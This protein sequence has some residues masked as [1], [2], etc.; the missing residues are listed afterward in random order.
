MHTSRSFLAAA[1]I[2]TV[3]PILPAKNKQSL[4][5]APLPAKVLTAKTIFIQNETN[6]PEIADKAYTQLK[7][8]GRYQVVDSKEK[9]DLVLLF[10]LG[11]SH[12]QHQDS[13]YVSLYNSQTGAYTS[14][15]VPSGTT[16][17]TWTYTQVR[18][19]DAA[20]SD[21]MWADERPWLRKHSAT[22]ELMEALKLRVGEQEQ[23]FSR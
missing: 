2:L 14:G 6:Q 19:I 11:Y 22:D 8:W 3:A 16:T 20:T 5:H 10:T 13:D 4:E 15:V 9:A 7:S 21:V 18:V 1:L 23:G 12:T 17:V